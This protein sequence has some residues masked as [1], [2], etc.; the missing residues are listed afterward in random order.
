M[1]TGAFYSSILQAII[2]TCQFLYND[3][4]TKSGACAS[5]CRP[6]VTSP[7]NFSTQIYILMT[8]RG[9]FMLSVAKVV[10]LL[11]LENGTTNQ[12]GGAGV[13]KLSFSIIISSS[14]Y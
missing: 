2:E 10:E 6:E 12:N 9:H 13:P 11:A 5:P 14:R 1:F 4:N 7:T 3:R 8:I